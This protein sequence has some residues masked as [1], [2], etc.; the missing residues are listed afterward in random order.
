MTVFSQITKTKLN[1]CTLYRAMIK[2]TAWEKAGLEYH[3][4]CLHTV[5]N[6]GILY[7]NS[8]ICL[9]VCLFGSPIITQ[10]PIDK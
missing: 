4:F 7:E 3:M 8:D 5:W 1:C 9:S 2:G 6:Q 10:K